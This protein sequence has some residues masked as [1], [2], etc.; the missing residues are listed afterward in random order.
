MECSLLPVVSGCYDAV[1]H[2]IGHWS[3][4]LIILTKLAPRSVS[5]L[6]CVMVEGGNK[7]ANGWHS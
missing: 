4:Q 5:A 1:G 2:T 7:W 3:T 6:D